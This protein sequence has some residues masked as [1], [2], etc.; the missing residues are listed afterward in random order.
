MLLTPKPSTVLTHEQNILWSVAAILERLS[1]RPENPKTPLKLTESEGYYPSDVVSVTP[2]NTKD[3]GARH[4]V[5]LLIPVSGEYYGSSSPV[6]MFA[7]NMASDSVGL[8]GFFVPAKSWTIRLNPS[9]NNGAIQRLNTDGT[10]WTGAG[11]AGSS[12]Y[13]VNAYVGADNCLWVEY[14]A[15]YVGQYAKNSLGSV[16]DWPVVTKAAFDVIASAPTSIKL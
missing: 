5:R 4:V 9:V 2:I 13:I 15:P 16:W 6:W 8:V 10:W 7:T 14:G 3:G 1:T 12:E 11:S